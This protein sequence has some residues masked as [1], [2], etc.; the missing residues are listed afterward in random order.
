VSAANALAAERR[1]RTHFAGYRPGPAALLGLGLLTYF[2]IQL[3]W[4]FSRAKTF[5]KAGVVLR[6][7]F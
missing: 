1:L 4:V 7:L 6:G 3:T 5:T 2:L